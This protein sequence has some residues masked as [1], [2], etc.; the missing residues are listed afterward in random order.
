MVNAVKIMGDILTQFPKDQA[1][2]TT[3]KREGYY[4]AYDI[5]G[6]VNQTKLRFLLRDFDIVEMETKVKKIQEIVQQVQIENP[7]AEIKLI[8]RET[9][10]NMKYQLDK[11]PY[12]VEYAEK[13]IKRAGVSVIKKAIRGGTDGARLS[14]MGLPTPN[15]FCG[16]IN[17]HSKKEFVSVIAMEKSI[18][19]ILNL[20]DIYVESKGE[21]L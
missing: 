8:L 1:P 2:E 7:K 4:H 12:V 13:A 16:A 11:V 5:R 10:K 20:I 21:Y 18:K 17:F 9:Y 14:Y 15:I 6:D 19:T 3:E